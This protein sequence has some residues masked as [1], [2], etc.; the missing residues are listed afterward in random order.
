[1]LVILVPVLNRPAN[2]A[3]LLSSIA[4][5]TP[6]PYRVL[7][8]CD[9]GDIA[10]QDAI[11]REGGWM[12]SPGGGYA[13]KIRAGVQ[14]TDEPYIFIGADD[15]RFHNGWLEAATAAMVDG[16]Q[17][18]GVN[19][20]IRRRRR[21]HATHFLMTRE[22]SELPTLDGEPGPLSTAY[23]HSFVD[24]ELIA[25]ATHRGVYAYAANAIVEHHHWM[26]GTARDDDTYK[27][28]RGRFDDDRAT[29]LARTPLW[30]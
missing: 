26:V 13:S 6:Q 9:P 10:E 29:F 11:A 28:G 2:V 7:F 21:Q 19:D 30:T 17:V 20:T 18:V 8:I 22:Y 5:N 23:H 24:D 14:A 4:M 27:R 1:V 25:T 16:V 12:I 3:P 15:L